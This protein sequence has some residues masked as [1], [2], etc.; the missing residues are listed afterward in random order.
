MVRRIEEDRP[1]FLKRIADHN[2]A[3]QQLATKTFED[4]LRS[5]KRKLDA[6]L[7]EQGRS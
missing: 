2:E 1:R 4:S 5:A 7:A 3:E 6:L